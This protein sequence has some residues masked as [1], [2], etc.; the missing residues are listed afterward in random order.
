MLLKNIA[1]RFSEKSER[2]R[3]ALKNIVASFVFKALS[4][5][6]SLA[7]IP[8]TISYLDSYRYGIWITVSTIISW[9]HYFDFG[10]ANGFRNK[11]A[12]AKATEDIHLCKKYVSTTYAIMT[13]L[14]AIVF[15]IFY[16]VNLFLNWCDILNLPVIY[17][18]EIKEMF[19]ILTGVLCI[20]MIADVLTKLFAGDQRP[21]YSGL[22]VV[23]GQVLSLAMI[24]LLVH[25]TQGSLVTLAACFSSIPT[26]TLFIATFFFFRTKHYKPYCPSFKDIDFKLSKNI[27][28]MGLK[29]FLLQISIIAILQLIN[30][31]LTRNCGADSVTLYNVAYKYFSILLLVMGLIVA[32]LWSAFTDAYTKKDVAWMHSTLKKCDLLNLLVIFAGLIAYFIAPFFYKVWIGDKLYIPDTLSLWVMIF[33]V[34]QTIGFVYMTLINGIGKVRIQTILFCIFAILGF[35]VMSLSTT[36]FGIIGIVFLPIAVY[37]LQTV[38]LRIQLGKL[39]HGNESG[40]WAK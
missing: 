33:A 30:M 19:V 2:T 11:F 1:K 13:I 39:I 21:A 7:V 3:L 12:E 16:V 32:P 27:L 6:V 35:P 29:F 38:F 8:L 18:R 28:G 24:L 23:V 9:V 20:Q 26:I 22:I 36:N 34:V 25:N 31:I 15:A 17:E 5:F 14:M 37:F 4:I 10:L 40:I